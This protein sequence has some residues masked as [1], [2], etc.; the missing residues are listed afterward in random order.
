MQIEK[1]RSL[2]NINEKI[3]IEDYF[4]K[5]QAFYIK[6]GAKTFPALAKWS[7]SYLKST[8]SQK[9]AKLAFSPSKV[10][11]FNKDLGKALE[12]SQVNMAEAIDKV[13]QATESGHY[14]ILKQ[15]IQSDLPELLEDVPLPT[16]AE[17]INNRYQAYLWFGQASN[18]AQLHFDMPNN[19]FIQVRGRKKVRLCSP[20][21]S[22]LLYPVQGSMSSVSQILDIDNCDLEKF[23][24]LK[25]AKFLE[26]VLEPGDLMFIPTGWWHQVNSLETAISVSFWWP[27]LLKQCLAPHVI[28]GAPYWYQADRFEHLNQIINMDEFSN[29]MRK[30]AR[31]LFECKQ[32]WLATLFC[33]VYLNKNN[34]IELATPQWQQQVELAIA[35]S[36]KLDEAYSLSVLKQLEEI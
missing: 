15:S 9:E 29:D 4:H 22:A 1:L 11:N 5:N 26:F 28:Q 35:R 34:R 12:F 8:L 25:D 36:A 13:S 3:F 31:K 7:D 17:S 24:T 14:Y 19:I 21:Q 27:A 23:S 33:D 16:W 18:T 6:G 10:F 20:E 2:D 32:A 30:A